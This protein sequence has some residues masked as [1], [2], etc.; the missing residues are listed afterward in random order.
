MSAAF[1]VPRGLASGGPSEAVYGGDLRRRP[2]G[3][4][5]LWQPGCLEYRS[6][7]SKLRPAEGGASASS[8]RRGLHGRHVLPTASPERERSSAGADAAA[9]GLA[10][11]VTMALTRCLPRRR[12]SRFGRLLPA[13]AV[14]AS[15]AR[16]Q[17]DGLQ[18]GAGRGGSLRFARSLLSRLRS[19]SSGEVSGTGAE[20]SSSSSPFGLSP[21]LVSALLVA[22]YIGCDIS[23]YIVQDN[24][25]HGYVKQTLLFASSWVSVMLGTTLSYCRD[26]MRGVRKCFHVPN[27]VRLFPV[28]ASF[29]ISLLGLL[30]AF[31]YF[32]GAFI[33]LI[34][35]MKLPL[36]ALLSSL[37]LAR[38][39]S[40]LQWQVILLITLACTS[41]TALKLN[42]VGTYAEGALLIGFPCILM[43]IV[44]NVTATLLAEKILKA[45]S[46]FNFLELMVQLRLGE[47]MT[48]AIMLSI[49]PSFRWIEFFK[50][51]D[52]TTLCVLCTFIGDAWLSALMVKRLSA[53]TKNVSKCVTLSVLYLYALYTGRQQYALAQALGAIMIVQTTVLFAGASD[54]QAKA[55][56]LQ[57]EVEANAASEDTAGDVPAA[58]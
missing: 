51:W 48:T 42:G 40:S 33:K 53:V 3:R 43:W 26:G 23:V 36:T 47:L 46:E 19:S 25:S 9:F 22:I 50:G 18:S 27:A 2:G 34:G 1:A 14:P 28:A 7:L 16:M 45:K 49:Y 35:Q 4:R 6:A 32:D 24:A 41:F 12:K 31:R 13:R 30:L 5:Q 10:A 57:R 58:P 52:I 17:G 8:P 44:F 54:L 11:A 38:R 15:L 20:G 55:D 37:V 21:I 29:S 39:Y 56:S